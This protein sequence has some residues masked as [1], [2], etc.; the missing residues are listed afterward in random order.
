MNVSASVLLCAKLG[1][2]F[3][4]LWT[5]GKWRGSWF[6]HISEWLLVVYTVG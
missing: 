4:Q 1:I 6:W 2:S 5:R 3:E